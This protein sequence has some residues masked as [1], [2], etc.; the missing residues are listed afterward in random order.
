MTG[1][2]QVSALGC[3]VR[4]FFERALAGEAC[5]RR[6]VG[7]DVTGLDEP[8]GAA[9]R[10][11]E[12]LDWLEARVLATLAPA[13]RFA[14]AAAAQAFEAAGLERTERPRGGVFVGT[15]F[16]GLA[17]VEQTYQ[18]LFSTPPLRPRPTAIPMGMDNA[19]AGFLATEFRLTGPNLTLAVACASGTHAIGQAF[20]LLRAGE[21]D[22]ML[23]GGT[24]A[25][26]T[27]GILASWNVLRVLARGE[28]DPSAACRPFDVSRQG[29]VV[30]EGAAFLLLE[31]AEHAAG[32][33]AP[34]LAEVIGYGANA[35]ATHVTAPDRRGVRACMELALAD[36]RIEPT[37]VGYINA[38]GTGTQI[39]DRVEA[40]AIAGLFGD[41]ASRI[42]VSATK[43]VHGHAMG[44]SGGLEAIATILA[45]AEGRI[46]PTAN[47]DEPDPALPPL[48]H[49]RGGER[50][51]TVEIALSNSFAFGGNNAVLVLERV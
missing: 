32:R 29:L 33:G 9:I 16:G 43:A 8:I 34:I 46:P 27:P 28:R 40:Q 22:L 18:R 11:W 21:V 25:P 47:L 1:L 14:Y 19:A 41:D 17:S 48:D 35:D 49:V 4:G 44:A 50:K 36:A 10:D 30:G 38:H 42:P 31:T 26:L 37:A 7:F 23:A 39:N 24:D 51:S 5:V 3:D 13:T 20:R 15:G 6:L 12:P 2:G 45:L